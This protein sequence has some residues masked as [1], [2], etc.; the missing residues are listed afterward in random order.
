MVGLIPKFMLQTYCQVC[1]N[2]RFLGSVIRNNVH[3]P[4]VQND[5]GLLRTAEES[6]E[7]RAVHLIFLT[8]PPCH[9]PLPVLFFG[10]FFL[11][12][13]LVFFSCLTFRGTLHPA[14]LIL[15]FEFPFR[16]V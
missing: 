4:K 16:I 2:S 10:V 1:V 5:R 11:F 9:L 15:C 3:L 8:D 6:R 7:G 13:F 14:S 12:L